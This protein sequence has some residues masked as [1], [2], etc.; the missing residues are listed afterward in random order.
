MKMQSQQPMVPM[1]DQWGYPIYNRPIFQ[2]QQF[3][4][5]QTQPVPQVQTTVPQA[6][7]QVYCSAV[8]SEEEAKTK[9]ALIELDGSLNIFT[10]LKQGVIYTK[11]LENDGNA[12]LRKYVLVPDNPQEQV[13]SN[14][15]AQNPIDMSEYVLASDFDNLYKMYDD[16]A[17]ELQDL[18]KDFNAYVASNSK[19][20]K[21]PLLEGK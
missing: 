9:G 13:S 10:N 19:K 20:S 8:T 4:Q 3:M 11:Q 18:A 2:P 12:P 16:L 5:S 7:Q 14:V 6:Q 1:Y 15:S 17:Y 21:K